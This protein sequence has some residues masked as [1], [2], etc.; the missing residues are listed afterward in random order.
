MRLSRLII[1]YGLRYK[2]LKFLIVNVADSIFLSSLLLIDTNS[3]FGLKTRQ[4][5]RISHAFIIMNFY[6]IYGI[7]I[8]RVAL[9]SIFSFF[10]LTGCTTYVDVPDSISKVPISGSSVAAEVSSRDRE[11]DGSRALVSELMKQWPSSA[12]VAIIQGSVSVSYQP[13]RNVRIE[14]P[15]VA[16]V[17]DWKFKTP[18]Q[19][20]LSLVGTKSSSFDLTRLPQSEALLRWQRDGYANLFVGDSDLFSLS[21]DVIRELEEI[22]RR[23]VYLRIT[24]TGTSGP[25]HTY[26]Y[27]VT[28]RLETISHPTH[29]NT[30]NMPMYNKKYNS[31][32]MNV[33]NF[34][35]RNPT[36]EKITA[37]TA[38]ITGN[39]GQN[40]RY[41]GT[42]YNKNGNTYI[43]WRY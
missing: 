36:V 11:R 30:Y 20:A 9:Y 22:L 38:D 26:C 1:W 29:Y 2:K 10:V 19:E 43:D 35:F 5:C 42:L 14:V 25:I 28:E 21:S 40:A 41:I 37:V 13:N 16:I 24:A 17:W 8:G 23:P 12:L 32:P 34:E 4:G 31:Q 33:F 15:A 27:D 6:R 7:L 39:C 3:L 18:L